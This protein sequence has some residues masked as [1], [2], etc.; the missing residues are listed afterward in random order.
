[1]TGEWAGTILGELIKAGDAH[2]QTG[3]FGTALKAAEYSAEGVPLISVGEVRQ[4][5][6]EVS[7][8]TPRVSKETTKRLPKFILEIGDIVFGRKGGIDRNAIVH[9]QQQGWFL[10]SDGIRLRLSEKYSSLFFSYQMRSPATRAWLLQNCEGTTMPS[11]NQQILGRVPIVLPPI[12]E[13]KA[14]AHILGALDNKIEL[15]RRMNVTLEAMARALFQSW[16]VDFDPVRAKLDGCEPARLDA[17]TAA[18]FP[19][20]FQDSPLGHIPQGWEISTIGTKLSTV[21]GGTPSREKPEYW[22]GGTVAWINSG[23]TNEFRITAPSEMITR[24]AL[25]NSS[26]KLLPR[27]T[28][29]LAITGATLGQVSITE[30]ECCANQ[31]VVA[32]PASEEFPTEFIYPWIQENIEKLISSQTGGAQQHINKGNVNELVLLCPDHQVMNA[33]LT[34]AKPLFDQIAANCFQSRT[35]ATL[36]DALLPK[37]VSGELRT[38]PSTT[39]VQGEAF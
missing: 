16:F 35:L 10:G 32:I 9:P 36:R 3:P 17:Y 5:H 15:N 6:F 25:E 39:L 30:I 23:K 21:L 8:K 13:Q 12:T 28:T 27:R 29:V 20:Y 2:L 34:K 24:E 11:L 37:L 26:T 19:A 22:T 7:D 1:M 4:G 33:Y 14:I 38:R 31:S 18:L